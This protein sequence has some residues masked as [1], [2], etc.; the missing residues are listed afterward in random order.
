MSPSVVDFPSLEFMVSVLVAAVRGRECKR[1]TYSHAK[2]ATEED[3]LATSAVFRLNQRSRA[4]LAV[5]S[6]AGGVRVGVAST[7]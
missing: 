4:T 5:E 1:R 3:I 6:P 2:S 7:H